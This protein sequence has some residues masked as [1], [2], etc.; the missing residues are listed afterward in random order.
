MLVKTFDKYDLQREFQKFDRDYFSLDGYQA[1]LDLFDE[2]DG[3][4]ELDVIGLVCDFSEDDPLDIIDQ[5]FD[6]E[7]EDFFD[8][9]EIVDIDKLMD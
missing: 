3:N 1:M 8:E 9:D 4:T 6:D 7:R 5:Y 2:C